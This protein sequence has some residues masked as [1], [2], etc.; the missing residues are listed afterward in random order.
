MPGAGS[1]AMLF[2]ME[3]VK[4][5]LTCKPPVSS[6]KANL[7][8]SVSLLDSN[9]MG[10]CNSKHSELGSQACY[11]KPRWNRSQQ[12]GEAWNDRSA[13]LGQL[14]EMHIHLRHRKDSLKWAIKI[15]VKKRQGKC[16][17]KVSVCFGNLDSENINYFH[18]P[19]NEE[20][21]FQMD[22]IPSCLG[23]VFTW[24]TWSQE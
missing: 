7:V 11:W 19:T 24:T 17:F 13:R 22:H 10:D 14:V 3:K 16:L 6:E 15:K 2:L 23:G 5:C 12:E 18:P 1:L 8:L 9:G 20:L 4:G 21:A